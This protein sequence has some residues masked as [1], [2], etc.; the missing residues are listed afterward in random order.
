[1]DWQEQLIRLYLEICELYDQELFVLTERFSNNDQP[2]FTDSEVATV[3]LWGLLAGHHTQKANHKY[4]MDHLAEW[5]PDLPKYS[6]Y[7]DRVNRL[8][9]FLCALTDRL[10]GRLPL[11]TVPEVR[12]L[13]DSMPIMMAKRNN[14]YRAK[15]A[16][17]LADRTWHPVKKMSYYG[18]KVHAIAFSRPGALPLPEYFFLTN[19]AQHDLEAFRPLAEE[20]YFGDFIGDR[21][22]VDTEL[23][24]QMKQRE[25]DL[26]TPIKR[27]RNDPPLTLFQ[28][29]YN[30]LVSKVRQPIESFFNWVETTVNIEDAARVRSSNGLR[31]HIW[32]KLAAA[33]LVLAWSF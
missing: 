4:V 8:G 1:M 13:I 26:V 6:A 22:Y 21:A 15:V 11:E 27:K 17:E 28:K 3:Y 9:D 30:A 18:V 32:G 33:I 2:D 12:R 29:A 31:V 19:A 24:E 7:L 16:P 23:K 25:T 14:S 5:F 10:L 20:I